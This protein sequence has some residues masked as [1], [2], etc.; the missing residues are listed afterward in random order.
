MSYE[1]RDSKLMGLLESL[2]VPLKYVKEKVSGDLLLD[3]I[4]F[5]PVGPIAALGTTATEDN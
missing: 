4:N 3:P 5:V 1:D 2:S